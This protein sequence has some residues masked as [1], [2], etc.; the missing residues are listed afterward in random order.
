MTAFVFLLT[1]SMLNL[2]ILECLPLCQLYR[3]LKTFIV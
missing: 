3:V 2:L 1:L